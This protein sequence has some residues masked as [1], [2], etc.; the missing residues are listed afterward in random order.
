MY[1]GTGNPHAS[2]Q[3]FDPSIRHRRIPEL[4]TVQGWTGSQRGVDSPHTEAGEVGQHHHLH[5]TGPF[6][7][8]T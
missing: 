5:R 7:L 2:T 4:Q 8:E 1:R 6:H 3:L